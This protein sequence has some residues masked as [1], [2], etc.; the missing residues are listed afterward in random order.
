[1]HW[2][3]V[4]RRVR[5]PG[6]N[7]SGIDPLLDPLRKDPRFIAFLRDLGLAGT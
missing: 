7:Q 2:L 1:M 4:G 3:E 5:D 6:V